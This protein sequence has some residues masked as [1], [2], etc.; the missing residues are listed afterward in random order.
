M[1]LRSGS[2]LAVLALA[3]TLLVAAP[4]SAARELQGVSIAEHVDVA[5]WGLGLRLSGA[6]LVYRRYLPF[7]TVALYVERARVDPEALVRGMAPCRITLHWLTPELGADD[8]SAYWHEQFGKVI[9]DPL[10]QARLRG[11]IE[12]VVSAFGTAKRGDEIALDYHPDRGLRV[13]RNGEAAGSFA[14][15]EL[16]RAI[17][18]L[19]LGPQVPADVRQAL[20]EGANPVTA[21]Q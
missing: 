16:N 14:G 12:R 11:S 15:L 18:H 8:A 6:A 5:D 21:S 13:A 1:E 10:M 7:H 17:L 3:L 4:P 9:K 2:N 20:L 19:W